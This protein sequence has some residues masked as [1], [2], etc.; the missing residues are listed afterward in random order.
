[1]R[2]S[3]YTLVVLILIL[4]FSAGQGW[5]DDTA[6][7]SS[8]A[9]VDVL[10]DDFLSDDY[11]DFED[12]MYGVDD[13]YDPLEPL[14]RVFFEFN[15]RMYFWV[16]KPVK[17]GYSYIIPA[18]LRECL[19]NFFNNLSAPIRLVNNLLQGRF[20]DAGV[21]VLRFFINSTVGVYGLADVALQEFNLEPRLADFGQTL[22]VY[23]LGEGVYVCWPILGPSN[24]RHSTGLIGDAMLSPLSYTNMTV[25]QGAL[26]YAVNNINFLSLSPDVYEEMKKFSLDPYIATRQSFYDFRRNIVKMAAEGETD[27]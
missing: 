16:W 26:Y 6:E 18:E 2:Q 22:G 17:I 27:F 19:G 20:E 1:M 9:P 5:S 23:G 24:L 14:N 4:C 7:T 3:I 21:V 12:D 11:L 8:E 25:D 15:D 13:I 10:Q